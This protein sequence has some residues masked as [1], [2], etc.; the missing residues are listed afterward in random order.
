MPLLFIIIV[1]LFIF[2]EKKV[3]YLQKRPGLNEKPFYLIKFRTMKDIY[4]TNGF[5]LPDKKRI[6][7][8]GHWL[9]KYSLD[10]LP[11]LFNI[12]RGEMSFVGPRPL[13]MKYLPLYDE[14]QRLRHTV[15]PGL[16]GWAQINGRN[17]I[18]WKQKFDLDY[19]YV[20]RK[21]ILFD[22]I[23]LAKS[24]LR[25]F[26]TNDVDFDNRGSVIEFNGSN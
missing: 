22:I 8:I 1:T 17:A 16:T 15:K 10:E 9:R 24:S 26:K 14:K 20:Q 25:L 3:F 6:T 18:S 13:L 7:I 4:G 5:L 12:I 21:S 19:E 23:I 11:Q 2:N